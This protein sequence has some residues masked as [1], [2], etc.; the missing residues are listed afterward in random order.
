MMKRNRL[1][2]VLLIYTI[3]P[4]FFAARVP[5][6]N[7]TSPTVG[8]KKGL[9]FRIR[10]GGGKTARSETIEPAQAAKLTEAAAP[11]IFRRRAPMDEENGAK[12]GFFEPRGQLAA[13]ENG[14][15]HP[16]KISG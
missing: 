16:G 10:E 15:S 5:A 13:A 11:A 6:Q 9:Q 3:F 2:C 8:E 7:E 14:K 12:C 1:V 4:G